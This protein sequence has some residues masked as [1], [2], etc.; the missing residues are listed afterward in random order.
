MPRKPS[1]IR[2]TDPKRARKSATLARRAQRQAK[3][4]AQGRAARKP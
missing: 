4:T 2:T 3:F 1:V